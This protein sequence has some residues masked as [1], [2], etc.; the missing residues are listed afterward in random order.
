MNKDKKKELREK[1]KKN[2]KTLLVVFRDLIDEYIA[3]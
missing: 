1:A 2:G 3:K